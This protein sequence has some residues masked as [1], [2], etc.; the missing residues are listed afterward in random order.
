L[1]HIKSA[2]ESAA[3]F[4]C[5]EDRLA[6]P[7]GKQG[8]PSGA[9]APKEERKRLFVLAD[10]DHDAVVVHATLPLELRLLA[11]GLEISGAKIA[12]AA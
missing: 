9:V 7:E 2:A 3:L 5:S 11:L 6:S 4:I 12:C 1:R 8:W 10:G